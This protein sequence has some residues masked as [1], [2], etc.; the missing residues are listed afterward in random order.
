[1]S[2][3][4]G[5]QPQQAVGQALRDIAR[6][7]VAEGR[8]AVEDR[9]RV[10]AVAVH[11]FR[12][13]MKS[14]RA[15]LRLIEPHAEADE[16]RWRT[17]ARDLA[18]MLAGARDAQAALDAVA[19]TEQH[20]PSHRLSSQSWDTIR[21]KLEE[22]RASAETA[23]LT[24][25][26]RTRISGALDRAEARIERWPLDELSFADVAEGLRADYRRAR[27]LIP[28]NWRGAS[29]QDLHELRQR[30][31]VHRY[32]MEIVEPLWPRLGRSWVREAQKLRNRLGKYQDLAVLARYAEP[33][34]PLA[35]WRSRLQSVISQRQAQHV[36]SS[37]RIAG[38]LFSEKPK[39]FRRR[40]EAMWEG[41][42]ASR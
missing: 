17:E 33:H 27:H 6:H 16:R 29:A 26:M 7:L 38:R 10:E 34:Q 37:R 19:D 28:D 4:P 15:F 8:T 3:K 20:A 36:A 18:R 1:M 39:A 5:L 31:V 11:D 35:R 41:M 2:D 40:L 32:Q 13:A 9:K 42:A 24:N 14:W 23:S 30:V 25:A 22:L 12:A 21:A